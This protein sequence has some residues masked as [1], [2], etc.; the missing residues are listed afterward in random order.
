MKRQLL[1][2]TL[3]SLQCLFLPVDKERTSLALAKA[4]RWDLECTGL[5]VVGYCRDDEDTVPYHYWGPRWRI[6][7]QEVRR[8]KSKQSRYRKCLKK[9]SGA[10]C[11]MIVTVFG[12]AVAALFGLGDIILGAVKG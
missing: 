6:L 3:H 4:K 5:D 9:T 8:R 7:V 12:V 2:E 10:E 1:L 11:L